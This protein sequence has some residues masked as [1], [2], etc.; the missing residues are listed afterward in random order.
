[1]SLFL[2]YFIHSALYLSPIPLICSSFFCCFDHSHSGGCEV[3]FYWVLICIF[4]ITDTPSLVA[5]NVR[6][7]FMCSLVICT[8]LEKFLFKSYAHLKNWIVFLLSWIFL[9]I[10]CIQIF[11]LYIQVIYKYFLCGLPFYFLNDI[12]Q[13]KIFWKNLK[14]EIIK[15]HRPYKDII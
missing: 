4:L 11:L 3:V 14:V 1:M 6:Y 15:S 5:N 9:C 12:F 10:F 7:H 2:I 8:S 13:I